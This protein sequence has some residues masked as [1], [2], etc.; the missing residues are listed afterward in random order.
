SRRSS[1]D[2]GFLMAK[3][4]HDSNAQAEIRVLG[5]LHAGVSMCPGLLIFR[6]PPPQRP[7]RIAEGRGRAGEAKASAVTVDS[8]ARRRRSNRKSWEIVRKHK[9]L[10]AR[11][12]V[13]TAVE[14]A[15]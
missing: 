15:I 11:I 13:G 7:D 8:F 1:V 2:A 5:D 6:Q 3:E 4:P 14:R 9:H 12:A 10:S